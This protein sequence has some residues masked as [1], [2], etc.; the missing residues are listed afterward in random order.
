MILLILKIQISHSSRLNIRTSL[1][2]KYSRI[3]IGKLEKCDFY[4]EAQPTFHGVRYKYKSGGISINK[5]HFP[6]MNYLSFNYWSC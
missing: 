5:L 3:K 1:P 6:H 4:E 2:A